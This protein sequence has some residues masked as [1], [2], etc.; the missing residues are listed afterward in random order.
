MTILVQLA[1]RITSQMCRDFRECV[2][3]NLNALH[4]IRAALS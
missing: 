4:S 3:K 2:V 1:G